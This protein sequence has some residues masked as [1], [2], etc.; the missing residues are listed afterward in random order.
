MA[1]KPDK[2]NEKTP[3]RNQYL[4]REEIETEEV[5]LLSPM[6]FSQPVNGH[7]SS[8]A[9]DDASHLKTNIGGVTPLTENQL[10]QVFYPSCPNS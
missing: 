7:L 6:V 9:N 1:N 10:S 4:K 2:A 8:N 3:G 5:Q